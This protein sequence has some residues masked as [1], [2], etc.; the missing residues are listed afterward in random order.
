MFF[1]KN[2]MDKKQNKI[3]INVNYEKKNHQISIP[4]NITLA[5]LKQIIFTHFQIDTTTFFLFY[6][7]TKISLEDNRPFYALVGREKYPLFF[8]IKKTAVTS[9]SFPSTSVSIYSNLS[10]QKF[11]AVL[12]SFFKSKAMPFN[13]KIEK[14]IKGLYTVK[15]ST[16]TIASE[17]KNFF[18]LQKK[19]S[20]Y[21]LPPISKYSRSVSTGSD[22]AE[23]SSR[24]LKLPRIK[25]NVS[26]TYL[27][28]EEKYRHEA[29]L[30]KKNWINKRG[31]IVSVG[32][33]K[34][35]PNFISNYVGMT[36]SEPPVCYKYRDVNK[37]KWITPK[38]FC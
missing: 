18:E 24:V 9:T 14:N 12:V 33:Y 11:L 28:P 5:S 37:K 35:K 29:Y 30:D 21:T 4:T 27:C 6:K 16:T 10:E 31:F 7:N 20:M 26:E 13:A 8:I 23:S 15:F 36:P 34:M 17:F 2:F 3:T 32:K 25:R 1:D 38:G 19:A 22:G